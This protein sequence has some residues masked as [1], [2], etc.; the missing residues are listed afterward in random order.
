VQAARHFK[1]HVERR[2]DDA[3]A[4]PPSLEGWIGVAKRT[5]RGAVDEQP[6]ARL[7]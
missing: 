6:N 7:A 3:N 4:T 1:F 5:Q 2:S